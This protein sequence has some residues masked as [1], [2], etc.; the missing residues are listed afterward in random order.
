MIHTFWRLLLPIELL[1]YSA[2]EPAKDIHSQLQ[3]DLIITLNS[4]WW[5]RRC[6]PG[7]SPGTSASLY[8][9]IRPPPS[10]EG[11]RRRTC[12]QIEIWYHCGEGIFWQ[13]CP[14]VMYN[15]KEPPFYLQWTIA[16]GPAICFSI[17]ISSKCSKYRL[18][19]LGG[20]ITRHCCALSP[21]SS[22]HL[23]GVAT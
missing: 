15:V 20:K 18:Q 21:L 23:F 13:F 19:H 9:G 8:N 4:T 2:P 17:R 1:A 16:N 5:G 6:A 12:L 11:G 22:G 10:P 7:T 3:V 14:M